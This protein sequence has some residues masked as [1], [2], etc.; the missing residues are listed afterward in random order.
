MFFGFGLQFAR[1]GHTLALSARVARMFVNGE[2]GAWYDPSDMSTLSQDEAGTVPVTAAGQPVGRIL[3]ISGRG[4]HA[5]QATAASR[6]ILARH[7]VSG[8]R[9]MVAYSEDFTIGTGGRWSGLAGGTGVAPVVTTNQALAPDGSLTADLLVLNKGAGVTST[10][11]CSLFASSNAIGT[12]AGQPYTAFVWL[13]TSDGTTKSVRL[14]F[15]GSEPDSGTVG[16]KT[17]TGTWQRFEV[18]LASAADTTRSLT[19]RLRGGLGTSD[20]A[21]LHVWGASQEQGLTANAYQKTDTLLDITE[22]GVPD[23]WYLKFD[24]LDD[25]L[26]TAAINFTATDNVSVFAGVR[27]LSDATV[28]IVA[29]ISVNANTNNG[30][31]FLTAPI[32][33]ATGNS[34]FQSRGTS[35]QNAVG[36]ATFVAPASAVLTG[37]ADISTP[38]VEHRRNGVSLAVVTGS[39]GTGNYGTYPLFIGRRAGTSLPFT[40]HLYGLL[41]RGSLTSQASIVATERFMATKSGVVIP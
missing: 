12:V 20:S 25:F 23:A 14:D 33:A 41:I 15:N 10:D 3:D 17:V 38:S 40:G 19:I 26:V 21:S 32:T 8:A 28:A 9:N 24:G 6:P 16:L 22:A 37:L 27:K 5:T 4:N 36:A 34:S 30:A 11:Q 7:P 2:Q 1:T 18:K 29:E 39:Q 31:W 13:K 35:A